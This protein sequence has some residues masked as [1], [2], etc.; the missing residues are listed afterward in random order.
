MD[1]ECDV[2]IVFAPKQ[3]TCLELSDTITC[4]DIVGASED[5][6]KEVILTALAATPPLL[7]Q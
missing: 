2:P 1:L 4:L 6:V 7:S 5:P 3:I